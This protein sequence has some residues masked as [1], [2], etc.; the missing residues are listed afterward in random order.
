MPDWNWLQNA[1]ILLSIR[2]IA[3]V[4]PDTPFS[5]HV[6]SFGKILI[7]VHFFLSLSIVLP[8][9]TGFGMQEDCRRASPRSYFANIEGRSTTVLVAGLVHRWPNLIRRLQRQHH[10]RVAGVCVGALRSLTWPCIKME[11]FF[12]F[13]YKNMRPF[14]IFVIV[15]YY[16]WIRGTCELKKQTVKLATIFHMTCYFDQLITHLFQCQ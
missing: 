12:I 6:N 9:I 1:L 15:Q 16:N 10:S 8:P 3:P 11:I 4:R 2:V 7:I 13:C 14:T 5:N